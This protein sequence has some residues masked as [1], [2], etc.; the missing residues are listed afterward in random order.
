MT[1]NKTNTREES[2]PESHLDLLTGP[3]Y[4]ILTTVA[5]D[6]QPENTVVWC[7]WDGECVLVNTVEGRRKHDN[8]RRN[9]LVA[10]TAIDTDNPYRWIDVRGYV[11]S[12]VPD[13]GNANINYHA[14]L[15]EGVDAY[16]GDVAPAEKAATDKR[17]IIRIKPTN[18][19]TYPHT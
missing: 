14:K 9:P 12:V 10:L 19:V 1:D 3:V 15:Y 8:I 6:G 2:I 11:E 5:D 16:Y 7:S 17:V 4:A 18:V 13:E